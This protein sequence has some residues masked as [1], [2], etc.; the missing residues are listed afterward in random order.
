M[1]IA[2][3]ITYDAVKERVTGTKHLHLLMGVTPG[4]YWGANY[5]WDLA[6][7]VILT[8]GASMTV[9]GIG[10]QSLA[11]FG[12][13]AVLVGFVFSVTSLSYAFSFAMDDPRVRACE[14]Q[15]NVLC[16]F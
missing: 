14:Q 3:Q 16:H 8:V 6:T 13:F 4:E 9:L 15:T 7:K 10:A 2:S 5:A 11:T 12:T 1:A